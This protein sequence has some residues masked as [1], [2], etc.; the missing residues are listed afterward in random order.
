MVVHEDTNFVD[1]FIHEL[2]M[3]ENRNIAPKI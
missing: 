2:S 1:N 3:T